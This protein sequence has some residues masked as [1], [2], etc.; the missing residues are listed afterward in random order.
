MKYLY[1][2]IFF[3]LV[4]AVFQLFTGVWL[5]YEKFSF[6]PS[7][8]EEKILGNSDK[9]INPASVEGLLK[10][11]VPHIFSVVLISF[12]IL[13]LFYFTKIT[14][15]KYFLSITVLISG[16]LNTV[17]NLLILKISPFFSY[18]K[19]FLF[20]VFE[21]SIFTAVFVLFYGMYIRFKKY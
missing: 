14:T 12:V 11:T 8:I 6:Y 4:A 9:F 7:V 13:H 15:L 20:L 2:L 21:V 10:V 17:S 3:F 18:L 5:F 19:L 16:V 1:I